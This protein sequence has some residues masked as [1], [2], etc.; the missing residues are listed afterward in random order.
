MQMDNSNF[1]ALMEENAILTR[2]LARVQ[3]RS[4]RLIAEKSNEL[5]RLNSQIFA[6]QASLAGKDNK[7][8]ALNENLAALKAA[9]PS[10]N[11]SLRLQQKIGQL[12]LRQLTLKTKNALLQQQL[13][14]AHAQA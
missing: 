1:S 13:L 4:T 12:T 8:E 11:A 3:A 6:L 7:I 14:A 2:E 5:A 9:L 10:F